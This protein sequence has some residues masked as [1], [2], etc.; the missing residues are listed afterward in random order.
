VAGGQNLTSLAEVLAYPRIVRTAV[1]TVVIAA[2]W[3]MWLRVG[4]ARWGAPEWRL[5][6]TLLTAVFLLGEAMNLYIQPQ[7]PQMQ[8]QPMT[9]FPFAV[10]AAYQLASRRAR[11]DRSLSTPHSR[12]GAAVSGLPLRAGVVILLAL[13]LMGN[14]RAY[15]ALRH[16]DSIA[17]ANARAVEAVAPPERTVFLLHGFEG[18]STWMTLAWGRGFTDA[19]PTG[20]HLRQFNVIYV[21]SEATLHPQR[22]PAESAERVVSLVDQALDAGFDVIATGIWAESEQEWIEAFATISGPEKPRAIRAA[23]Y[24]HFRA[25]RVGDVPGWTPLF[26]LERTER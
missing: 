26:R 17:M 4:R 15:A 9:W 24:E 2:L 10:A 19:P 20:P 1:T 8:I 12:P 14:V 23:L 7:D 25:V 13:L 11:A 3:V 22:P 5:A 16:A 21:A 6:A 18:M